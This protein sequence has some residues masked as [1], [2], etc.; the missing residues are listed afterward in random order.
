VNVA[1]IE[2]AVKRALELR[3][4]VTL[5]VRDNERQ[6][7]AACAAVD[8]SL[9]LRVGEPGSVW[10]RR[11]RRRGEAWLRDHGFVPVIDAWSKPVAR[12]MSARSCAQ[13]LDQALRDALAAPA[14]SDL[15]ET[16]VHPGVI[17]RAAP[18]PPE[19]PHADHIRFALVALAQRG[20]GKLVI[21]GGRPASTWA[22]SFVIDGELILSPESDDD[23]EW[24]VPLA[25]EAVA[26]AADRLTDLLHT[27]LGRHEQASLFIS[28]MPL[29][30]TDPPLL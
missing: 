5:A 2:Q 20:R 19:A 16:L 10:R 28:C 14:C 6:W 12:A 29:N 27:K 21:E 26:A 7:C 11:A 9:E 15:V 18:P 22:W 17:G 23:D 30:P 4:T 8:G 13:L 24:T 3:G 1:L 25:E